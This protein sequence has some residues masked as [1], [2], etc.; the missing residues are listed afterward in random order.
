MINRRGYS[1]G[2]HVSFEEACLARKQ[3]EERIRQGTFFDWYNEKIRRPQYEDLTGQRFGR[4]LVMHHVLRYDIRNRRKNYWLCKCDCGKETTVYIQNLK[5]GTTKSCGCLQ[6]ENAQA[7]STDISGR[8]FGRLL[9][10][11]QIERRTNA[12]TTMW[13]CL[14]DCGRISEVSRNSLVTGTTKSCGCKHKELH[15]LQ[16]YPSRIKNNKLSVNNTS[17]INGV[18][19][20]RKEQKWCA[21]IG[22]QKKTYYLGLYD[23]INEAA[24]ARK[25]AEE[26]LFLPFLEWYERSRKIEDI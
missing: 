10:L 1:L 13:K 2:Y 4:L 17:G 3:A 7:Q 21:R 9:A 11:E 8:R 25:N 15:S 22:F 18:T 24:Q 5:N 20:N 12:G 19:W 16:T 6:K 14:C 23:D 26:R